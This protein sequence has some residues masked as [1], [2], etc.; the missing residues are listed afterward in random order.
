MKF[1]GHL[2][3]LKTA[4]NTH[5]IYLRTCIKNLKEERSTVPLLLPLTKQL[6]VSYSIKK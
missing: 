5:L 3:F 6:L 2:V 1:A 4:L